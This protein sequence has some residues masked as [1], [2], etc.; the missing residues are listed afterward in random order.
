MEIPEPPPSASASAPEAPPP[1]R[2]TQHY[3]K[4]L[5]ELVKAKEAKARKIQSMG[6]K[7]GKRASDSN[8]EKESLRQRKRKQVHIDDLQTTKSNEEKGK[9]KTPTETEEEDQATSS[10][11]AVVSAAK[12][13][14][15]NINAKPKSSDNRTSQASD[16]TSSTV[17]FLT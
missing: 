7:P 1:S 9:G 13:Q 16:K 5:D 12:R 17:L 8:Q 6:A 2:A 3:Q 15:S 10:K 11:E 4:A 14:A